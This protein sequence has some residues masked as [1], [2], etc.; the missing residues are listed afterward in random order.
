MIIVF[1]SELGRRDFKALYS[2]EVNTGE[3]KKIVGTGPLP[4]FIVPEMV[5]K[6]FRYD[7]GAKMFKELQCKEFITG[8]DAV[9]LK[10]LKR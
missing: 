5:K 2:H 3:V 9:I 6:Y 4:E 1:K 7:S 10:P 8:T